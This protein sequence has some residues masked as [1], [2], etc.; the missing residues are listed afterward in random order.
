MLNYGPM[1]NY[2]IF[3]IVDPR[4]SE[5]EVSVF[6]KN[7]EQSLGSD[8]VSFKKS[9]VR[10]NQRLSYPIKKQ[11]TG[12]IIEISVEV[13]DSINIAAMIDEEFKINE[14][15]LRK[16][17]VKSQ[18]LATEDKKPVSVIDQLRYQQ[19]EK[20]ATFAHRQAN[21]QQQMSH[22]RQVSTEVE[23][24]KIE[25]EKADIKQIDKKI[26]ELLQ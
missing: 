8:N 19:R 7:L 26:E 12:H 18:A 10:L 1:K 20:K 23:T 15:V 9:E 24:E 22:D 6:I 5:E 16:L 21:P 17:V 4:L 2:D 11:K 3:T 14:K 13:D 25:I